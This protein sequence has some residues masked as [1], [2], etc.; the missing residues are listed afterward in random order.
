MSKRQYY[1]RKPLNPP[2]QTLADIWAAAYGETMTLSALARV[3]GV[4]RGTVYRHQ[5]AGHFPNT[6]GGRIIT[7]KAAEYVERAGK[8]QGK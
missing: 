8:E 3:L 2:Q 4:S 7:R 1:P 6:F 5:A